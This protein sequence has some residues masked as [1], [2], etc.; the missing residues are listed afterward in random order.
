MSLFHTPHYSTMTDIEAEVLEETLKNN[1]IKF[2]DIQANHI[3]SCELVKASGDTTYLELEDT[4]NVD[5]EIFVS[6]IFF[7]PEKLVIFIHG[8]DCAPHLV[9]KYLTELALKRTIYNFTIQE[10]IYFVNVID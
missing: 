7:S 6:N 3:T 10:H 2:T 4:S 8:L 5:I 1:N 9:E